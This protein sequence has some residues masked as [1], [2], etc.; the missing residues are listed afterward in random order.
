MERNRLALGCQ[1]LVQAGTAANRPEA[2][3][4]LVQTMERQAQK[5]SLFL[6]FFHGGVVLDHFS[7]CSLS[8]S[9]L[10]RVVHFGP[11]YSDIHLTGLFLFSSLQVTLLIILLQILL[12][13][14]PRDDPELIRIPA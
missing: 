11:K 13:K 8:Q 2:S 14:V 12:L 10:P 5:L 4:G 9:L 6:R 3:P 7:G 1:K